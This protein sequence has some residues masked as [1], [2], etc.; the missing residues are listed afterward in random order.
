MQT[1]RTDPRFEKKR[2]RKSGDIVFGSDLISLSLL[3]SH[4]LMQIVKTQRHKESSHT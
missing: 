4:V 2:E 3:N 1:V